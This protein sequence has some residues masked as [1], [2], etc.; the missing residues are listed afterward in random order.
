MMMTS[1]KTEALLTGKVRWVN[2]MVVE[3]PFNQHSRQVM[4]FVRSL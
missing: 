1:H 2:Q 3:A 4:T